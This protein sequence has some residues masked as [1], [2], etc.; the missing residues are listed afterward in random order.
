MKKII[1]ILGTRP[2]I[3]R[4]SQVI[5]LLD[6]YCHHL[7]VYTGQNYTN[8][9]KD[10]F[11]SD[12]GVRKPDVDFGIYGQSMSQ[13]GQILV[14]TEELLRKERPDG[15]LI[16][17]D[18]NSGLSAFVAK[19]LGI[20]VYHMEAGNR[21][22][23]DSVPEEVNRKVID[24]C[25]DILMPYTRNSKENLLREGL[26]PQKIFVI[27]N[28]IFEVIQKYEEEISQSKILPTLSLRSYVLY[29]THRTENVDN[30]FLLKEIL[31][32]MEMIAG[33]LDCDVICSLHPRTESKMKEFGLEV[34]DKRIRLLSPLRFFDFV[35]LERNALC[36]LTDSGTVQEECCIF[37]IP[38]VTIRNT[39][40]RPET[41]DIGS[42]IISGLSHENILNCAMF[43]MGN[44]NKWEIPEEYTRT[45]VSETV[46]KIILG[47]Y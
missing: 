36:V 6:K 37:H 41:I 4:L 13:I 33:K 35:C 8:T 19:R 25:S 26:I 15:I 22:F 24:H 32:S 11:F 20:K 43:A 45:N 29:T 2:E 1:T 5:P 31:L 28:P 38:N 30:P 16:L 34:K 42:N 46:A 40:E 17:G 14:K 21:C 44:S 23:D 3:I 39:T 9:L 27:G 18:T 7:L 10:I 47:N 12:L